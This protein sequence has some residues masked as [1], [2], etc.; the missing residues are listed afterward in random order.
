MGTRFDEGYDRWSRR[1]RPRWRS[2]ALGSNFLKITWKLDEFKNLNIVC[3]ISE[4]PSKT[5]VRDILK[6]SRYSDAL[7][8]NLPLVRGISKWDGRML[9]R[10]SEARKH[11]LSW[12]PDLWTRV[13]YPFDRHR[14][15]VDEGTFPHGRRETP[16]GEPEVGW[17]DPRWVQ[18]SRSTVMHGNGDA[19]MW[20]GYCMFHQWNAI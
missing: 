1:W 5:I 7:K 20:V 6:L 9:L 12:N 11:P 16:S 10:Y 3:F 14:K 18:P 15:R 4:A 2:I 8:R 13:V 19:A 17:L